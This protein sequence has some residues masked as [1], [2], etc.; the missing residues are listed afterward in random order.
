M[1]PIT[2]IAHPP[3]RTA[4][5]VADVW[6][7]RSPICPGQTVLIKPNLVLDRHP[8][9]GDIRCLIAEGRVLRQV[10][11]CVHRDLDGRGRIIVGD[12]PL[13]TTSFE[14]ALDATGIRA[15]VASFVE[16]TGMPVEVIDFRQVHAD[17]DERGHIRAWKEVPGDPAG[18]VEI[19]L[20]GDSLLAEHEED[21]DRFRV[22]NYQAEDTLQYH[23]RNKHRYVIARTVLDADVIVSV[24]KMKTHCKVGVTLSMKNFVGTV[25]RKQCLAHHR[26]GGAPGG[27]DEYPDR[28]RLKA[29]SVWLENAID[30][31]P[32]PVKRYCFMW[33]YRI[34][35][36]LIK[37][38]GLNPIRDGGWHGNDTC[39]RMTLD[40]VRIAMY[41]RADGT[42]A[43]TPQR[44]ILTV[45]DGLIAGEGEGPL[46]ATPVV[47][48]T[49]V[50]GD[51]PVVTDWFTAT[52][53]GFDPQK[54]HLLREACRI[55]RWPLVPDN[56]SPPSEWRTKV[57]GVERNL[58]ELASAR[59]EGRFRPPA[60]WVGC[61]ELPE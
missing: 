21:S 28:G 30:G 61:M 7:V 47:A 24:P 54:I 48:N 35:E 36:R 60:G 44:H 55:S 5:R 23:G 31:N 43:D 9:G 4:P 37:M 12:S 59:K 56:E 1:S 33:L 2:N 10:L 45:V 34:N 11:A 26:E 42:M 51:N 40:L 49:L 32:R 16:E 38:L 3:A 57:D 52:W 27:G 25:G 22:S 20:D 29:L 53:M 18:Y 14:G 19:D 13:Q 15:A 58:A 50:C 39:W 6:P 41:G 17:R 46:E 8:R